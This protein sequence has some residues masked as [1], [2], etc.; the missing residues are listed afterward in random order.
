MV[1][2]LQ[3]AE[4]EKERKAAAAADMAAFRRVKG[5][6]FEELAERNGLEISDGCLK[7]PDCGAQRATAAQRGNGFTASQPP[8]GGWQGAAVP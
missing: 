4:A 1:E 8:G 5:E 3:E 6:T 2:L 7:C